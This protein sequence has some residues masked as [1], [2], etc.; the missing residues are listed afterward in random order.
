MTNGFEIYKTTVDIALES[1]YSH[2][3]DESHVK[4]SHRSG[5][6]TLKIVVFAVSAALIL[7]NNSWV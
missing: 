7:K 1:G 3:I 5:F 6:D 4:V 2:L